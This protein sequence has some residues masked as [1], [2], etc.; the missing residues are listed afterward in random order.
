MY[1]WEHF[2]KYCRTF[3]TGAHSTKSLSAHL[4]NTF[5]VKTAKAI[6]RSGRNF[7]HVTTAVVTCAKSWPE[8]IIIIKRTRSFATFNYELI[9]PSWNVFLVYV[10][11]T[12]SNGNIFCVTG[13]LWGD[14]TS[15]RWIPLTKAYDAELWCFFSSAS[16]QT[17]EYT[18]ETPVI[19]DAIAPIMMSL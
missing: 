14:F 10:M 1:G 5:A 18:I 12:A 15:H 16:E 7:A 2:T 11:M 17:V 3:T 19:W 9:K 4:V 6:I 13:P 8:W